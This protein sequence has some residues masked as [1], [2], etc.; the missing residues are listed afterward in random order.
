MRTRPAPVHDPSRGPWK[1]F[2]A[3]AGMAHR[4]KGHQ[5]AFPCPR[6]CGFQWSPETNVGCLVYEGRRLVEDSALVR[7]LLVP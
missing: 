2:G 6:C 1:G 4:H 7:R 3:I 5:G